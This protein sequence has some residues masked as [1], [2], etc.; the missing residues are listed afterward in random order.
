MCTYYTRSSHTDHLK[1][2]KGIQKNFLK[3]QFLKVSKRP[4]R[5]AGH[6]THHAN[7]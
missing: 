6:I 3:S 4:Q 2:K 5:I 1:Y 7:S